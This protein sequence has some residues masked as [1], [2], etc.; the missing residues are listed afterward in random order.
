MALSAGHQIIDAPVVETFPERRLKSF[1]GKGITLISLMACKSAWGM[2][3]CK[4]IVI[5]L[6]SGGAEQ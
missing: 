6:F 3:T 2:G 1:H 4:L 5:S